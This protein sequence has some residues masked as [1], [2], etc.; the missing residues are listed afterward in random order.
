VSGIDQGCDAR[1]CQGV[2][3]DVPGTYIQINQGYIGRWTRAVLKM[4]QGFQWDIYT[5]EPGLC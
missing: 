3:W 5:D 4:D 2:I 1:K